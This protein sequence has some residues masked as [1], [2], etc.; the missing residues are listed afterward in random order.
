MLRTTVLF[1]VGMALMLSVLLSW[2]LA[3]PGL[4]SL[5]GLR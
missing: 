2:S 5:V 4:A 3:W 1:L